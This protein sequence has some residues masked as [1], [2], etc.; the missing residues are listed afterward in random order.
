MMSHPWHPEKALALICEA[1][2]QVREQQHLQGALLPVLHAL[3]NHFGYIHEDA[4]P[5]VAKALNLSKAEVEG[6]IG[7]YHDF[8]RAHPGRHILRVSRAEACQSMGC[9]NLIRHLEARL[10]IAL[11]ETTS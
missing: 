8:R 3:Q 6:V 10:G 7:F 2:A 11:G 1:L 9:D 5:L 4:V